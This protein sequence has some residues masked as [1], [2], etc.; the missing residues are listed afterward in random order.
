[1]AGDHR[2]PAEGRGI[3]SGNIVSKP[4]NKAYDEG[5]ERTF[6]K[7]ERRI[8]STGPDEIGLMFIVNGEEVS[9]VLCG[10]DLL[11]KAVAFVLATSHNTGRPH[12]EWEVRDGKGTLLET[13]R[14]LSEYCLA[15]GTRLFVSLKA[16]G[17]GGTAK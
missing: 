15:S 6:G 3:L 5:W 2:A 11:G 10:E 12:D 7:K 1:M 13:S 8:T 16:A 9:A 14:K 4:P 17:G